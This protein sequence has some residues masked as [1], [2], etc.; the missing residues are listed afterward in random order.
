MRTRGCAQQ[1][2]QAASLTAHLSGLEDVLYSRWMSVAMFSEEE[3]PE[4]M[5]T[6]WASHL[7]LPCPVRTLGCTLQLV[8]PTGQVSI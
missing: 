2:G 5:L 6:S 1:L 3:T 7:F 4:I 8:L